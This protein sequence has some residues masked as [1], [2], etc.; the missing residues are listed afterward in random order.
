MKTVLFAVGIV[1]TVFLVGFTLFLSRPLDLSGR[2]TGAAIIDTPKAIQEA[3]N[4]LI[5]NEYQ[6]PKAYAVA[7]PVTV[8]VFLI[9]ENDVVYLEITSTRVNEIPETEDYDL[10]IKTDTATL[11]YLLQEQSLPAFKEMQNYV[12]IE[13]NSF[14]GTIAKE[15]LDK[16]LEK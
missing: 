7:L 15:V 5:V 3:V 2:T 12:V 11:L 16:I 10:E 1:L 13:S 14:K 6:V 4:E 8:K 9:D